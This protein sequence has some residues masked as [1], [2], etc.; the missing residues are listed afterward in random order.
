[1]KKQDLVILIMII[2]I[3][4][5]GTVY[6]VKRN[7]NSVSV[8]EPQSI[9]GCYVAKLQNDIYALSINNQNGNKVS[10]TLAY[11]NFQKDSSHGTFNGEI[12]GDILQGNYNFFSEGMLSDRQVIFKKLDDSFIQGFGPV[13]VIDGK[14]RFTDLNNITFNQ[15]STFVKYSNCNDAS[16]YTDPSRILSFNYNP[17]WSVISGELN[18]PTTQWRSNVTTQ[19]IILA[20]LTIQ[21]EF[22]PNTNFSDAKLTI[23]RSTNET[24]IR[25]C[26]VTSANE[27]YIGKAVINSN[28]LSKFT[29][30]EGA[31]GNFYGT[32]SYRGILDGDCYAIEYI[33]HSTN[34]GSYSPDQGINQ[35]DSE[36]I[37]N[38]LEDVIKSIK[39]NLASD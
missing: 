17:F 11:K 18:Q 3:L 6:V 15:P 26:T 27:K 16:T 24:D 25:N 35:F 13:N 8:N 28:E 36:K 5:I 14:E 12:E 10:G 30:S 39:F 4:I 22:M 31:A 23:G 9:V 1:M 21:K 20:T 19:G 33:I 38:D 29:S 32:T 2:I 37:M 34:L 7:K